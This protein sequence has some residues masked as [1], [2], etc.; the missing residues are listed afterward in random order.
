[1]LEPGLAKLME[2]ARGFKSQALAMLTKASYRTHLMTFFRF[3]VFYGREP[4]PG[5]SQN[6]LA[7]YMAHLARTMSPG[8]VTFI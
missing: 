4:V 2:E 3:C 6:T 5:T 7:C 1:M 8:S